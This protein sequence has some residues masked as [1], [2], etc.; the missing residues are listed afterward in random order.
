M[1]R[2]IIGNLKSYFN[3]ILSNH[4]LS[5]AVV[6]RESNKADK[7][8]VITGLFWVARKNTLFTNINVYSDRNL[9]EMR[10]V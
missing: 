9:E 6:M 10:F 8:K 4:V 7:I 2:S 5:G 1:A 3:N